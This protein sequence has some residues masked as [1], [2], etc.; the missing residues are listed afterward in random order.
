MTFYDV[1]GAN[2]NF[3]VKTV[4]SFGQVPVTD[5]APGYIM[6]EDLTKSAGNSVLGFG[7][8]LEQVKP[9]SDCATQ[10]LQ[11]HLCFS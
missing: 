4:R 9:V 5:D 7:M 11:P 1:L 6:M 8:T 2:E 10:S 3:P